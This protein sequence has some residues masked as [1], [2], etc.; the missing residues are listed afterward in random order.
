M[1]FLYIQLLGDFLLLAD[2]EPV[3]GLHQARL[4]SF[5][6][7]LLRH[8]HTPQS[9]RQV[10]FLFWPDSTERQAQTNLRKLLHHLRNRLPHAERFL[11]ND[12]R[13]VWWTSDAPFVVDVAEFE[14]KIAQAQSAGERGDGAQKATLLA[15][16]VALYRGEFLRGC[17]DDWVLTEREAL[18]RQCLGALEQLIAWL[19][20][21][22]DY[23]AAIRYGH[24]LLALDPL[25]EVAYQRLM[26]LYALR[27]DRAGALRIYHTCAEQLANELNVEPSAT[28]QELYARLLQ[29]ESP[30][31]H[32]VRMP[33][34]VGST[35]LVG[36]EAEW[37]RL[38][39]AWRLATHGRPHFVLVAGEAGIGKT[40]L[41]EELREWAVQQGVTTA[42][43]R[44]Y[45]AAGSLAYAPVIDWLGAEPFQTALAQ[46]DPVWRSELARLLPDLLVQD[47][48][49]PRP[50]A[51]TERWQR[52]RLFEALTRLIRLTPS[53]L[54]LA[55]DDLQWCDVETLEWLHY[56]LRKLGEQSARASTQTRLMMVGTVRAE[57]LD[58]DHPLQPL[59]LELRR[60]GQVTEIELGPLDAETS[61]TLAM[62][63]ADRTLDRDTV[64]QIVQASEGSPL[65]VV[66][67]V[68]S[69]TWGSDT[70]SQ[71]DATDLTHRS[72]ETLSLPH[73]VQAVIQYRLEQL[74]GPAKEITR[75]S[76]VI[77]R[78]FT[79]ETLVHAAGISE[80]ALVQ[81]LD[82]LWHR[83]IVG[84]Y[85]RDGYDFSHDYIREV[86]YDSMSPPLRRH[87]HH[88]VA[89]ALMWIYAD[90]LEA[91][92]GQLAIHYECTGLTEQAV[93]YYQQA[94]TVAQRLYAFGEHINYLQRAV[95]LVSRLPARR[96]NKVAELDL[97]INL[98]QGLF[99]THS[100]GFPEAG[101]T[102]ERALALCRSVGE[103]F[104]L[105]Q[106]LH[107][108]ALFYV[109]IGE[110]ETA[111]EYAQ[112]GPPVA[113]T[114]NNPVLH[115]NSFFMNGF[116]LFQIAQF[117]PA[118]GYYQQARTIMSNFVDRP[119]HNPS[120]HPP[121]A[122]CLWIM[123]YPD[124]ANSCVQQTLQAI[125]HM[126]N[127][128]H[129]AVSLEFP[130]IV[131]HCQQEIPKMLILAERMRAL[132][133][134]YTIQMV[135]GLGM[136]YEGFARFRLGEVEVGRSLIQKGICTVE[137]IN[138][139]LLLPYYLSYLVEIS[140]HT[141]QYHE[142]LSLLDDIDA[143]IECTGEIWWQAELLRLRGQVLM[144]MDN[145]SD[146]GEACYTRSFQMARQQGAKSLE[147][148]AATSLAN[149]WQSQQKYT[150]AH[151]L[152][153]PIYG[154]FTEGFATADLQAAKA[155]LD[156]LSLQLSS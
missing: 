86:A 148:R 45:A 72:P 139:V 110:L 128:F 16:A 85:G 20:E 114:L 10:A 124:Q 23:P 18:H 87:L 5:L 19:E 108:L 116:T 77:G 78:S 156:E 153:A 42:H 44:A 41:V 100:Y 92:V 59:L 109:N 6:A 123:G 47:P 117:T 22:H 40:R 96:E 149:L 35:R 119:K 84:E 38:Q 48:S 60:S 37:R 81:V 103:N 29:Q 15:E 140:Q 79:I 90:N 1:P 97:L 143:K 147:L 34:R 82:E 31:P 52:Q 125:E 142:A 129:C 53:P 24:R 50:E 62:Q 11:R 55:L 58:A 120:W 107:N 25:H 150:E 63:A 46:L 61:A 115:A 130:I 101:R 57:E 2:D 141:R 94:A 111:V 106:I 56:L 155:L 75:I 33:Q 54:L 68:R 113:Q 93:A 39:G 144:M 26:R 21:T 49:L 30:T 137:S 133:D 69:V 98:A 28:T 3:M 13:M 27:G 152:L 76:A 83:R 121:V 67:M 145:E 99:A 102:L 122:L 105:Q 51:L 126:E 65:F 104:Q 151:A 118:L 74:S 80:I 88:R 127:P 146:K 70:R 136:I 43:T 154:W 8:C 132:A 134:Q 36:R 14:Q 9:R 71:G 4:Q 91:V 12:A 32:P 64:H 112:E 131:Q 89:M 66:E 7:Y 73:K 135:Q 95:A 138:L 17:Y